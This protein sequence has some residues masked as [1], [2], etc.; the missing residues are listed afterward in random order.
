[1]FTPTMRPNRQSIPIES[2]GAEVGA[3]PPHTP[4]WRSS[5][6][7]SGPAF[8]VITSILGAGQAKYNEV[9]WR[10]AAHGRPCLVYLHS[11]ASGP[12]TVTTLDSARQSHAMVR[13]FE[14]RTAQ[15]LADIE[16]E[17]LSLLAPPEPHPC[18]R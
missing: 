9:V 7:A 13:H 15:N 2:S 18:E 11:W 1:M 17:M 16:Q 10:I 8:E 5:S 6:V 14:V 12:Q 3:G 4:I